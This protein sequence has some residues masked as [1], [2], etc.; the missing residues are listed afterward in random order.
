MPTAMAKVELPR[1][2]L[3]AEKKRQT[4]IEGLPL[5]NLLK[6][7]HKGHIRMSKGSLTLDGPLKSLLD[8]MMLFTYSWHIAN[9][10][11]T[12]NGLRSFY[13]VFSMVF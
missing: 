7:K 13:W 12:Q 9:W 2:D 3:S 6:T 4:L 5:R 8:P 1:T 11:V 10:A